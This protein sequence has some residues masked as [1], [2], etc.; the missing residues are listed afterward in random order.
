[1]LMWMMGRVWVGVG[2]DRH[3]LTDGGGGSNASGSAGAGATPAQP[4]AAAQPATAAAITTPA[5]GSMTRGTNA[6]M[7]EDTITR[8]ELD[9][10]KSLAS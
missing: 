4:T 5:N 3:S 2:I 7:D 8:G 9:H 10:F 1:M 6:S